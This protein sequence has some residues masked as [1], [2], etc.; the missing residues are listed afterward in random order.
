MKIYVPTLF[1]EGKDKQTTDWVL[2]SSSL[3]LNEQLEIVLVLKTGKGLSFK[4]P[5]LLKI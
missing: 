2:P 1:P 5:D 3:P 4:R